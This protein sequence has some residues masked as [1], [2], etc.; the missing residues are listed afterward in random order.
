MAIRG[1]R[2]VETQEGKDRRIYG[3]H[4]N[5]AVDFALAKIVKEK[6]GAQQ[7]IYLATQAQRLPDREVFGRIRS[8]IEAD[9]KKELADRRKSERYH[10]VVDQIGTDEQLRTAK[11]LEDFNTTEEERMEN[12]DK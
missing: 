1:E 11:E 9:V 5:A 7:A 3:K 12:L 6:Y 10:E 8:L 2:V 4:I